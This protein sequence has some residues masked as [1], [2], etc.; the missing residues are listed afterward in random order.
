[1]FH[2]FIAYIDREPTYSYSVPVL[3]SSLSLLRRRPWTPWGVTES[4]FRR[5]HFSLLPTLCAELLWEILYFLIT[6]SW[7]FLFFFITLGSETRGYMEFLNPCP[8]LLGGDGLRFSTVSA[9]GVCCPIAWGF[10]VCR[11][12][13]KSAEGLALSW[14]VKT[15]S[16]SQWLLTDGTAWKCYKTSVKPV[17]LLWVCFFSWKTRVFPKHLPWNPDLMG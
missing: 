9:L 11:V 15:W 6:S 12:E 7:A 1:M 2:L 17:S 14:T 8:D 10:R 5:Q 4:G 16:S 13:S 3:C